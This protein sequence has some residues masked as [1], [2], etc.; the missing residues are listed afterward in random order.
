MPIE[1][2]FLFLVPVGCVVFLG[3]MRDTR[4]DHTRQRAMSRYE[5][6][7]LSF[8]MNQGQADPSVKFVSRTSGATVFLTN[9]EAVLSLAAAAPHKTVEPKIVRMQLVGANDR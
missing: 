8:E 9:T 3:Q 2:R 7:P 6:L 4:L 1:R 5:E